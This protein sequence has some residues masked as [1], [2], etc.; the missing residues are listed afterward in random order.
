MV[1]DSSQR[2]PGVDPERGEITFD[3][4]KSNLFRVIHVDGV[5][6]GLAPHKGWIQM[7]VYSERWPIPQKVVHALDKETG[8]LGRGI[9]GRKESR[10]AVVREVDAELML[11]L[12]LAT[13]IVEW[14][15]ERIAEAEKM[16]GAA[17]KGEKP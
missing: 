15:Q 8:K 16:Q 6:G 3:Y 12:P 4:I 13:R 5:V 10:D 17:E 14:L 7:A 9:E 11:S 2:P 1:A